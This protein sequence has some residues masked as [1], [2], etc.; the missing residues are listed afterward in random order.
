MSRKT[1]K[2]IITSEELT[3]Q[4]NPENLKL[5]KQFLK[6]KNTRSSDGTIKNYESDLTIFFTW[7]L[8][9]NDNKLF[10]DMRKLEL[11]EFFSFAVE[12][13]RWGSSRFSRCKATL[14]SLSN[15]IEKFLDDQ[16][17]TFRNNV[18]KA[19]ESMPK[20]IVRE[21]TVLTEEQVNN[22]L[23]Y[24]QETD[25]QIACWFALA[26]ASG[27]RFSELSRFSVDIIDLE[28]LAFQDIFIETL[29]PIKTKGR[30]K[31]GKLLYKY[32]I[33][34]IFVPYYQ[35]W[36]E[37]RRKIMLEHNQSHNYIFINSSGEPAQESTVRGWVKKIEDYLGIPFYAHCLRHYFTTYL[38]KI[39]LPYELIKDIVGWQDIGMV[40][41]YSDLSSKDK[42]WEE[43]GN[44]KELLKTY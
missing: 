15:F 40:Q 19:V 37:I 4:I 34:D 3:A 23:K 18:L 35:K 2:N 25:P 14:S 44:L 41:T 16:F 13:L 29:R 17:P 20:N 31:T 27:S 33:K 36:L 38:A 42:K 21:K 10:T 22:L 32:I 24:F 7:N 6:E 30:T 9:N 26:I 28:H 39:N 1:Y 43:L 5:M 12:E 11:S 8:L